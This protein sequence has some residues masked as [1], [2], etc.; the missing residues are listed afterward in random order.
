MPD[1][2]R[3]SLDSA[4]R[5]LHKACEVNR[6]SVVQHA[7]A[8]GAH[9]P[10]QRYRHRDGQRAH[11]RQLKAGRKAQQQQQPWYTCIRKTRTAP[12]C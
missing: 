1:D 10:A 9:V 12:P 2:H 4:H 3:T 7:R 5:D 11:L 6:V 8:A